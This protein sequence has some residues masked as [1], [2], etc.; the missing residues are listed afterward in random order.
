M[1]FRDWLFSEEIK[2][3]ESSNGFELTYSNSGV[4]GSI[5]AEKDE[6]NPNIYRVKRV[7]VKPEGMGHGKKLYLA[8][9]EAV[10]KKGGVLAPAKNSTSDSAS[11][12]WRSLY[13]NQDVIKTPLN[14]NDWPETPR[15][16]NLLSKYN[17]LRFSDPQTYPP[18]EDSEFWTFNSG[19]SLSPQLTFRPPASPDKTHGYGIQRRSWP[20]NDDL[21][22]D[23]GLLA[24]LDK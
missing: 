13:R 12:V 19:Y 22:L 21:N 10:G 20:A 18:K 23:T 16:K 3:Q 14:A 15:N 9:L 4:Q 8:A 5:Y 1:E 17:K 2:S 24:D 7:W 6:E 11:N